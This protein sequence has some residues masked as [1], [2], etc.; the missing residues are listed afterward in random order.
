M[1]NIDR[2]NKRTAML[3]RIEARR[4]ED[5]RAE[6]DRIARLDAV[7]LAEAKSYRKMLKLLNELM[8]SLP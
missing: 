4:Q 3:A 2:L 6:R 8:R 5:G 1:N 7:T